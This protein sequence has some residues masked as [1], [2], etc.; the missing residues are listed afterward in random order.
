M[1]FV[2]I[3]NT[4]H[5]SGKTYYFADVFE[6]DD[7]ENFSRARFTETPEGWELPKV[8]NRFLKL[9][10]ESRLPIS[11]PSETIAEI[12]AQEKELQIQNE[13]FQKLNN[14]IS[15]G[16]QLIREYL[17]DNKELPLT[18]EQ[19][20]TQLQKL[21][22]LKEFLEVGNIQDAKILLSNVEIDDVFTQE[23]KDKYLKMTNDH[24]AENND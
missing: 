12:L 13:K 6:T 22:G 19:S 11:M 2:C 10:I 7:P 5:N 1:K 14:D 21:L 20:Q 16:N 18:M 8:E 24:L 15:F 4:K 9:D 3:K 17:L 23:R